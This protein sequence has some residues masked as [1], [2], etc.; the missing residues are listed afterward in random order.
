MR[1]KELIYIR[2]HKRNNVFGNFIQMTVNDYYYVTKLTVSLLFSCY[3]KGK[4]QKTKI[5][6]YHV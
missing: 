6:K 1:E 5:I 3:Y 2:S 4:N